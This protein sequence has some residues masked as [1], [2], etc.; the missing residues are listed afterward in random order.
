MIV[1]TS[2]QENGMFVDPL[3]QTATECLFGGIQGF[4]S[5][6]NQPTI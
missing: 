5:T 3:G 2:L 4:G 6:I 1:P